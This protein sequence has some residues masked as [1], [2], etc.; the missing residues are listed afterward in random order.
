MV[1]SYDIRPENREG[2]CWFQRF[3]NFSL[4]YLDTCPLTYSA[5][6]HMGPGT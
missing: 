6:T 1:A 4:T 3:K 5:G 2:L